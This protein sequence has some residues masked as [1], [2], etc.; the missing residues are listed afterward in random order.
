MTTVEIFL[1]NLF[2]PT[3]MCWGFIGFYKNQIFV[4]IY[5]NMDMLMHNFMES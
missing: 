4:E 1:L 3:S 2:L 5:K